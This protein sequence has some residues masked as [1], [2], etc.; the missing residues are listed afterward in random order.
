MLLPAQIIT[1]R[2]LQTVGVTSLAFVLT[3]ETFRVFVAATGGQLSGAD[4]AEYSSGGHQRLGSISKQGNRFMRM[5]LVEAAQIAVR[6]DRNA[7]AN[8][9]CKCRVPHRL[10]F[11]HCAP[12]FRLLQKWACGPRRPHVLKAV[13]PTERSRVRALLGARSIKTRNPSFFCQ[14]AQL[15]WNT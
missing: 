7:P 10:R 12:I 8:A 3:M 14:G 4:S 11:N 9:R 6:Y 2:L 15:L 1:R 5:L 13:I